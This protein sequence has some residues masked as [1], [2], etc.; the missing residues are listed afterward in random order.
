MQPDHEKRTPAEDQSTGA[1]AKPT[2]GDQV[3]WYQN[4]A[5]GPFHQQT[6][7]AELEARR[8]HL[9]AENAGLKA[10][11]KHLRGMFVEW[12]RGGFPE[13]IRGKDEVIRVL[14]TRVEREVADAASWRRSAEYF[15]K[16]AERRP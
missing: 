2:G 9:I 16:I 3:D 14:R 13:V 7:L 12:Q 4:T 10:R 8:D 15:R 11:V 1:I 6:R 5:V